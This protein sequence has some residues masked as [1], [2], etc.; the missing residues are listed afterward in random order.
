MKRSCDPHPGVANLR[1][2]RKLGR[3]GALLAAALLGAL[4]FSAPASATLSEDE[5]ARLSRGDTVARS[6]T[7]E[8]GGG[9]YIGGVTY[10]IVDAPPRDIVALLSNVDAY[11]HVLPRTKGA[12]LVGRNDGELFVELRQGNALAEATY[13]IR[14]RA[15]DREVRFWLDPTK[16]H[17]IDDAWGFFRIEPI[18]PGPRGPR[19][20][21]TYG[22]LVDVGAGIVRDLF[23][24]KVR[25][26]ALSVPREVQRYLAERPRNPAVAPSR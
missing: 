12:R 6:Q 9:R 14:V 11:R 8:Q 19:S 22:V 26:L 5:I 16:P 13:T 21:V 7:I 2:M 18:A 20:L 25:G 3:T 15:S 24:E 23:E 4:A 10:T 1:V 17:G